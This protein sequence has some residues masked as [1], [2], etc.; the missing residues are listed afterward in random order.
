M[1]NLNP[2]DR[3]ADFYEELLAIARDPKVMGLAG[4]RVGD[5]DLAEDV[6]Q[7]ALYIVSRVRNPEHILSLRAYFCKVVIHEAARLRRV[8]G[9][10]PF[11]DPEAATGARRVDGRA[12]R[13]LEDAVVTRLMAQ[14]WLAQFRQQKQQLRAT[15]PGRSAHPDS[16]RDCIVATAE[17]ILEAASLDKF[18]DTR[19]SEGLLARYP[20]WLDDPGCAEN[21]RQQRLC[22]ALADLRALLKQVVRREDLLP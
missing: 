7:E 10:L 8:Q 5:R 21:S 22:R 19:P 13:T 9:A 11:D 4:W 1:S 17:A 3:P 20:E 6:I 2:S 12:P 15:I 18:A 14:T 16:Y